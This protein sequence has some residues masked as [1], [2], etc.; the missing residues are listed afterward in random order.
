MNR[1]I[2]CA[3]TIWKKRLIP[4]ALTCTMLMS[5]APVPAMAAK[6]EPAAQTAQTAQTAPT[7]VKNGGFESGD[8]SGWTVLTPGWGSDKQGAPAGV[9]NVPSNGVCEMPT[10]QSGSYH[11]SGLQNGIPAVEGWSVRSSTFLLSGSGWISV[12][13]GGRAA[14]VKVFLADG[15]QVGYY[16]Q[17][18][19]H[20]VNYPYLSQGGS[21]DDMATYVMDLSPYLGREMYVVLCD[22]VIEGVSANALFDDV[23]TYY[24]AAPD[25][26]FRFDVV[27]DGHEELGSA[28]EVQI[29]WVMAYNLFQPCTEN[30]I[31]NGGFET[32]DLTGWTV[33]TKGFDASSAVSS[34]Q[35][36]WEQE[37]PY[38][39]SGFYHLDGWSTG[40]PEAQGWSV[41][42]SRFVLGGS[43]YISVKMGGNAAVTKVFLSDGTQIG[44]YRNFRF[45]DTAFPYIAQGGAWC[46]M[47]TYVIDLSDYL[48]KELYVELHDEVI[49]DGWANAFFDDVVTYYE[50]APDASQHVDRVPDGHQPGQAAKI[51]QIPWISVPKVS[52]EAANQIPNG[53]F[54]TGDLTGWTL[55]ASGFP[56]RNGLPAANSDETYWD[57]QLPYNK[58]GNY[59]V[60]GSAL[61]SNEANTWRLRSTP[62]KLEGSG[63]ISVKMGGHAA[64]V[65]VYRMDG[66]L[67]GDFDQSRF[68]DKEFP[69]S[70]K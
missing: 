47:A 2:Q 59:F 33:L 24:N 44:Y 55:Y 8:L 5:A 9:V 38:N 49:T 53:D 29:P 67:V 58:S 30:S 31:E 28:A 36:Y 34:A 18:R 40:I 69:H 42:S 7:L 11:L 51:A 6:G 70:I 60:N 12:K 14:A 19:Y 48:G 65:R 4:L 17:N 50:E 57:Q 64:A 45:R 43:G 68:C 35:T 63:W 46:D 26:T 39:Q 54:E 66:T 27:M 62:F 13:M 21:W 61:S 22:E 16:R 23:I 41:R 56:I 1:F 3:E 32:G 15:T 52:K 25:P 37:L 20:D 10:N